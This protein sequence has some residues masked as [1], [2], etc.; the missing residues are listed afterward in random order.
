MLV[1]VNI[2]LIAADGGYLL[3]G[4]ALETSATQPIA[5]D[6]TSNSQWCEEQG[7]RMSEAETRVETVRSPLCFLYC[8]QKWGPLCVWNDS[9]SKS[10]TAGMNVEPKVHDNEKGKARTV[11]IV[12]RLTL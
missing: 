12:D 9:F 2:E 1:R 8:T 5:V 7:K 6:G 3:T 10:E 4:I 11:D